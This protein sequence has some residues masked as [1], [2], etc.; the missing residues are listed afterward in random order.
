MKKN[1]RFLATVVLSITLLVAC[2]TAEEQ[3]TNEPTSDQTTADVEENTNTETSNE[4]DT[5]A[6]QNEPTDDANKANSLTYTSNG[7]EVTEETTEVTSEQQNF[8]LQ[9]IPGFT[10]TPEEPGKDLLYSEE[11]DRISMRIEK[12]DKDQTSF[13]DLVGN[14]KETISAIGEYENFALDEYL[15]DDKVLINSTAFITNIEAEK[16]IMVVFETEESLVRLTIYD[17][18]TEDLKEAMIKMGLTVR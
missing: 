18:E 13:E 5:N 12:V 9:V 6:Q 8:T 2:N 3:P 1:M 17:E 4:L 14:T 7:S 11:N 10:L 15:N 16:V